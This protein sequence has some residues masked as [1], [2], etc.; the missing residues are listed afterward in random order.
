M[1]A[2]EG[3]DDSWCVLACIFCDKTH[4][5]GVAKTAKENSAQKGEDSDSKKHALRLPFYSLAAP[6]QMKAKIYS[7]SSS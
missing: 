4:K 2:E 6:L 1:E 3:T 7:T 5:Q